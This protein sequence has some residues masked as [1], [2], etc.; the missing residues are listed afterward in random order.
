[1]GLGHSKSITRDFDSELI[2]TEPTAITYKL[3]RSSLFIK[4]ND[5]FTMG[6]HWR[7]RAPQFNFASVEL[8]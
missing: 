4:V 1:M 2:A 5:D 6:E 7:D 3:A 8:N